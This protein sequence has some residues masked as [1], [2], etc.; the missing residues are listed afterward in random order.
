MRHSHAATSVAALTAGLT[1]AV[2]VSRWRGRRLP[3][4]AASA[5]ASASPEA[6]RSVE[7]ASCTA[8]AP[9]R[10][11]VVLPFLRPVPAVPEAG[12]AG[13]RARCGDSGGATKS[14]APC[15]A[16]VPAGGR[17]HHHQVAAA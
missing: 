10:E 15:A 5:G 1:A 2:V 12:P 14:G 16:R 3:A 6:L 13:E 4:A 7:A 8:S 17:C 11:G 9:H